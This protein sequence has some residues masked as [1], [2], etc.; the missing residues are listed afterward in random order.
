MNNINIIGIIII[1]LLFLYI[2]NLFCVDHMTSIHNLKTKYNRPKNNLSNQLNSK[3]L[4][5]NSLQDKIN[6]ELKNHP[7]E[8]NQLNSHS[9]YP[10]I[11]EKQNDYKS[12]FD[13]DFGVG[14]CT[15]REPNTTVFDIK[16]EQKE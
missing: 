13:R 2:I 3:T 8:L 16:F 9:K 10:Y 5:K 4:N 7:R 11:N 1:A 6:T 15:I 12:I 14:V